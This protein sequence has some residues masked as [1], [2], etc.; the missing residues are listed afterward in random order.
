MEDPPKQESQIRFPEVTEEL[1]AMVKVDQDMRYKGID[2]PDSWDVNVDKN[3]TEQM[4]QIIAEIG[5]PTIS[6]VGKE[7]SKNAW[8]LVQHADYNV[9]F[10]TQCLS[11]M[12]EQPI[13]EVDPRNIAYLTDRICVNGGKPQIY[14][15][16]FTQT[17]DGTFVPR[18]IDDHEHV[19]ERRK[20]MS[21]DT[22]ADN[23]ELMYTKYKIKKSN[24]TSKS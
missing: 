2:D 8:L 5:W 24:E 6:K 23:I 18:E 13:N 19:D 16:Q 12:K 9:E 17:P 22:L 14:G 21:M 10:Q 15:T 11:L 3:N 4:K 20:E 1:N 7:G